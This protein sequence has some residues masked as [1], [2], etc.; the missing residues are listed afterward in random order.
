MHTEGPRLRAALVAA[1]LVGQAEHA[2]DGVHRDA[3][4]DALGRGLH[5]FC[6]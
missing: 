5:V 2:P 6:E 1:G 3:V 4:V